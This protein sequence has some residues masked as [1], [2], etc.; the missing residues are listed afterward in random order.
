MIEVLPG[1]DIPQGKWLSDRGGCI[2]KKLWGTS[3]P[4]TE[5]VEPINMNG[6]DMTHESR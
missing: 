4:G 1:N 2:K 5:K 3:H 6:K